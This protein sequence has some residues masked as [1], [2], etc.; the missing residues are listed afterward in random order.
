[1]ACLA[2]SYVENSNKTIPGMFEVLVDDVINGSYAAFDING[3]K[4]FS[5]KNVTITNAT[6]AGGVTVKTGSVVK[7]PKTG[8][9]L[10]EGKDY[11]LVFDSKK[12]DVT[13]TPIE[14]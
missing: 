13:S 6:Y 2:K 4:T 12:V 9:V 5:A 3:E 11:E 10:T 14:V 8:A 1:M 7:D